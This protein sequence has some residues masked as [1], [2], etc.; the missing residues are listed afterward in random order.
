MPANMPDRNITVKNEYS[1]QAVEPRRSIMH[2]MPMKNM[3][4][5]RE[6]KGLTQEDLATMTGL[7]QGFLSKI[8]AGTANPT[9]QKIT[10]I[11]KALKVEPS[12]LFA[13]PDLQ[14]RVLAAISS[15]TDPAQKEAALVV[16]E[17]M[18]A[19]RK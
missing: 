16:L 12:E 8:E 14:Q 17:S 4:A 2:Y 19:G 5:I 18:A 3:A 6:A 13:L 7:G 9:L 10:L 11:A 1:C 15:I